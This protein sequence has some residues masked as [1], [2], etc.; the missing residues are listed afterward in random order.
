[1]F[2]EAVASGLA[3]Y[4]VDG[5]NFLARTAMVK[6][7]RHLDKFDRAK[8]CAFAG[9]AEIPAEAVIEAP[10]LPADW[11]RKMAEKHPSAADMAGIED[12]MKAQGR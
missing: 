4:D 1:M 12:G 11:L 8:H 7:E 6:D 5:F 9:L 2:F 3:T 10:V